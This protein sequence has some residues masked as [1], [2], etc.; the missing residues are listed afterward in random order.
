MKKTLIA[1]VGPTAIGKT[2]WAIQ[3]ARHFNTEI[4]STDSRQFYKEMTIGTAVP[5]EEELAEAPHH[6]IQHISISEPW[7]V[8]DFERAALKLLQDLFLQHKVVIAAGGSG[9]YLRTLAEGLDEFPKVPPAIRQSLNAEFKLKGLT[10]LQELLQNADPKYYQEVDLQNPHRLIRALEVFKASGQPYSAYLGK[11]LIKRPFNV[12]YLGI[13]AE[14]EEVYH[15]I[16]KRVDRMME[17]GLLNEARELFK[18]KG[19]KALETVGY[20]EIFQFLEGKW[21][22]ERAVS[23]IKKNTRRY[24]KR[25]LTWLRKNDAIIWIDHQESIGKVID[26]IENELGIK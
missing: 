2:S 13:G 14:R 1:V 3:L 11:N 8:G 4:I 15:R 24:A 17:A 25:Q 12:L 18:F 7:T 10:Y 16:D 9:L 21:D 22:L 20:Q 19:L 23:E 5:S 6:F 26:K